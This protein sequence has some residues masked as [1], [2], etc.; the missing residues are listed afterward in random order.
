MYSLKIVSYLGKLCNNLVVKRLFIEYAFLLVK[1]DECDSEAENEQNHDPNVERLTA[2]RRHC[3]HLPR[4]ARG[5]PE[6]GHARRPAGMAK[7]GGAHGLGAH[8]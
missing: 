7:R 4:G 2:T 6:A 3:S 8:L 5:R 1:D